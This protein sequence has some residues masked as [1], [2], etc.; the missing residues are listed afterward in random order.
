MV[1]NNITLLNTSD[2]TF[3]AN[4][5]LNGPGR[6]FLRFEGPPLSIDNNNLNTLKI[7]VSEKTESVV[8][9][10]LLD[11][12]TRFTLYDLQGRLIKTKVLNDSLRTRIISFSN[13]SL[14]VHVIKLENKQ[15]QTKNSKNYLTT[16]FIELI[17]LKS[18]NSNV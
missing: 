11:S 4:T 1:E 13:L 5:L 6:F 2:Y 17:Y 7:Y 3:T 8:I 15:G 12:E 10:G 16:K 18:Y 9:D 14:G